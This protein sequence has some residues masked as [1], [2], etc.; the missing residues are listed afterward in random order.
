MN[1]LTKSFD[2]IKKIIFFLQEML[3]TNF[4]SNPE[5]NNNRKTTKHFFLLFV[6]IFSLLLK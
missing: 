2:A 3:K 5:K 4:T 1:L 6:V